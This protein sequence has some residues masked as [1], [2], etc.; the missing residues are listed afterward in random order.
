MASFVFCLFFN[1][2]EILSLLLTSLL[3]KFHIS[4][5]YLEIGEVLY[6]T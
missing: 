6:V 3:V 1:S 4:A 2:L 5:V